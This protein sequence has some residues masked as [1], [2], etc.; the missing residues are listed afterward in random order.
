MSV[1]AALQIQFALGTGPKVEIISKLSTFMPECAPKI[2]SGPE[3][4][5]SQNLSFSKWK[6]SAKEVFTL[7]HF[8]TAKMS[9]RCYMT[10]CPTCPSRRATKSYPGIP[11]KLFPKVI[12]NFFAKSSPDLPAW[13][14]CI[15]VV[16]HCTAK[17]QYIAIH[18]HWAKVEINDGEW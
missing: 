14:F 3:S 18:L 13:R 10:M 16:R 8:L 1:G 12:R 11:L 5:R 17:L 6:K 4:P 15:C 7:N 9:K 2:A